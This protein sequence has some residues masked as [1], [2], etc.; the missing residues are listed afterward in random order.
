MDNYISNMI[1]RYDPKNI[2]ERRNAIKEVFQELILYALSKSDFFDQAAFYGGTALRIFYGLD[3]FS[4]DLDFSLLVKNPDFQLAS[5]VQ[6]LQKTL[7]CFGLKVEIQPKEKSID[8]NVQSAFLK[9]NTIE[10]L[11]MF[12][13]EVPIEGINKNEKIKV[14]FELDI[15][16]PGLAEYEK[17]FHFYPVPF[18]VLLYD[19]SSLFS[20]KIHALLCR[21]WKNRVK[22]RDLYDYLFYLSK[23]SQFNLPHLREKLLES[24]KIEPD[25]LITTEDVKQM[26]IDKFKSLDLEDAKKD[27]RPFINDLSVLD[28]WSPEYFIQITSMKLKEKKA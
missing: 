7:S 14:K 25:D 1:N 24:G 8:S 20:G 13:P 16:P 17:K 27:V 11:M 22:G 4:E 12:Y 28:I 18:E 26:L 10:Q 23:D 15:N 3:R 9:G 6:S 19:Q 21:G 2:E 5:F